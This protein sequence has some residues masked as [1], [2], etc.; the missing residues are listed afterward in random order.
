[1]PIPTRPIRHRGIAGDVGSIGKPPAL[2]TTN[3]GFES[4]R[5]HAF[6]KKNAD[7][8]YTISL[9]RRFRQGVSDPLFNAQFLSTSCTLEC[10]HIIPR[11]TDRERDFLFT[12]GFFR[13]SHF[14]T[15]TFCI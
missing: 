7:L 15:H 9:F 6:S 13:P 10:S 11:E 2:T 5:L 3:C 4:R 12:F 8:T 14:C 1:G